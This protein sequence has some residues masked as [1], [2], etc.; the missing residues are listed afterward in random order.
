VYSVVSY[1]AVA[2]AA[3]PNRRHRPSIRT[4]R[5]PACRAAFR[6]GASTPQRL[7]ADAQTQALQLRRLELPEAVAVTARTAREYGS[8]QAALLAGLKALNAPP[9]QPAAAEAIPAAAARPCPKRKPTQ[10]P[11]TRAEPPT[12]TLDP[13]E[14]ITAREAASQLDLKPS[15]VKSYIRNGKIDGRYD[16]SPTW[17][18]WVL[19]R[20]EFERVRKRRRSP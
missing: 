12:Q 4:C 10:Q 20:R 16:A 8:I 2:I 14:E 18:G 13:D 19:T 7:V 15:T 5:G 1:T 17:R 6:S 9:E 11:P 3:L